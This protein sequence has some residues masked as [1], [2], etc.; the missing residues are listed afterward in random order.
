MN[1]EEVDWKIS[2]HSRAIVKYYA[3]YTEFTE[4]EVVDEFLKELLKNDGFIEWVKSKRSNKRM[5]NQLQLTALIEVDK[6]EDQKD[7]PENN[8]EMIAEVGDFG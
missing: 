5:V 1:L 7:G 2:E 6:P 4:S 8:L 3:E